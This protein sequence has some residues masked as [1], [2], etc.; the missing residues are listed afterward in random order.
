ME[1]LRE[2]RNFLALSG[3]DFSWSYWEDA[4]GALREVDGLIDR[5]SSGELPSRKDIEFLFLPTGP[6]QEVSLSSG[7]GQEFL[8]ISSRLDSAVE[9]VYGK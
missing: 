8:E 2:T 4:Q 5:I 3:N 6:I 7:W 1:V 9:G